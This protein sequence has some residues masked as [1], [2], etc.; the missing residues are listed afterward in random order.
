MSIC[1]TDV[2]PRQYNCSRQRRTGGRGNHLCCLE[3]QST[4]SLC[5]MVATHER[6]RNLVQLCNRRAAQYYPDSLYSPS[7]SSLLYHRTSR[8]YVNMYS[9]E[10]SLHA[11]TSSPASGPFLK[12]F[13]PDE[14]S[15]KLDHWHCANTLSK[16]A[17]QFIRGLLTTWPELNLRVD[18]RPPE[19]TSTLRRLVRVCVAL[20]C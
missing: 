6:R 4:G 15:T 2:F 14:S 3:Y 8:R 1:N 5:H 16:S 7:N 13:D 19:M 17:R 11:W 20:F 18:E 9:A 12:S 10:Q